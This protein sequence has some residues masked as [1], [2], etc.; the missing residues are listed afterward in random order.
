MTTCYRDLTSMNNL[1][2]V[3][4]R[5]QRSRVAVMCDIQPMFHMSQITII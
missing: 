3:L 2:G 1:V 5:F 4:H